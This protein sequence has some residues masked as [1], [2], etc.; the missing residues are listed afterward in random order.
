[1]PISK[2][3]PTGFVMERGWQITPCGSFIRVTPCAK[4]EPSVIDAIRMFIQ[5]NVNHRRF[6][7]VR[8]FDE[9]PK[10]GVDR[11][12]HAVAWADKSVHRI[13]PGSWA[14]WA[15]DCIGAALINT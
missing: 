6:G 7:D 8:Y 11:R 1:M 5:K 3:K 2:R 14:K 13:A 10:I 12:A 4:H 15:G 9:L